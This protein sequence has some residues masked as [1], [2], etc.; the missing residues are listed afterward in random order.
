MS[1]SLISSWSGLTGSQIRG[2][3]II[4]A[5]VCLGIGTTALMDRYGCDMAWTGNFYVPGG[6]RG[7]WPYGA[8]QPWRFLYDYGEIPGI[9]ILILGLAGYLAA[10]TG[11]IRKSYGSPFLVVILT[12]ALGPGLLV[13]GI[14]KNAWG[15][16]RPADVSSFGGEHPYRTVWPPGT[17]GV[18]KSFPCGHCSMAF[19]LASGAA[20]FP[21]HPAL[22]GVA[23]GGGIS[24][25][26]VM[27]EARVAQGGHFPTDVVWAGVLVLAI[28]VALYYV[29]L[30]IP[31]R[32][33]RPP[34]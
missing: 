22:A 31:E 18:G 8:E 15:R 29:V 7:G 27:G 13:N 24:Y 23:L 34:S 20:F 26:I 4:A 28:V 25:G 2:L 17:P 21:L 19:A 11:K 32:G 9:V 10:R 3:R 12:V 16:P 5:L 6:S 14:L 1:S 30:R 33:R